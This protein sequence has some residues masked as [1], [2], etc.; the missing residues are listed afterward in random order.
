MAIFSSTRNKII[1]LLLISMLVFTGWQMGLEN[2]YAKSLISLTNVCL[3][4]VK[5]QT[6]IEFEKVEKGED[7]YQ[8]R[9]YTLFD[10]QL[11]HFPQATGTPME[12][13]VIILSWQ[14]F[15]FFIINRKLAF[16]SLLVNVGVF[17]FIQIFFMIM[18]TGYHISTFQQY[19]YVMMMDSFYI[20]ALILVIKDNMLYPVF[21]KEIDNLT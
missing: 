1:V 3:K 20:I 17:L 4:I 2:V 12:P 11:G 10:G 6:H 5:D 19:I 16:R 21:S 9:I 15:L 18:L 13:F 14:V 8:F 7:E